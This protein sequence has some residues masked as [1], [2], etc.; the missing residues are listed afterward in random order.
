MSRFESFIKGLTSPVSRD[1]GGT[2][3]AHANRRRAWRERRR[4]FNS[5]DVVEK[6][7]NVN[8][9]A[10]TNADIRAAIDDDN[11]VPKPYDPTFLRDISA[12]AVVQAYIDTLSQDVASTSWDIKPRDETTEVDEAV[13]D[14]VKRS[15]KHL[16]PE[17]S[18]PD[19]LEQTTRILLELGDA[20]WVKHY[21]ERGTIAEAIPVDSSTFFKRVDRYGITEGYVQA[22]SRHDRPVPFETR[23]VIWFEWSN[24]PDR[25]YGQGPLEKA[26]NEVELLEEL[27]YKERLDLEQGS[28]PGVL[29]P[30]AI[31]EFGGL[32]NTDDW[33]AFVD[34]FRLDEGERHR[35]GY[36]PIPVDYTALNPTYQELQ[37][38]ERSKYWVTVL[39]AVFKCNPSYVGFDFENTNR[40]TDE[41][42]Q[43]AYAQRGFRVTLRQIEEAIN[44]NLIWQEFSEDVVFE[45]E[46]EQTVDEKKTKAELV[47][48]QARAGKEM[49]NA[50]REVHYRDGKLVVEDG[51]IEEG[52]AGE[53]PGGGFFGMSE[54][55]PDPSPVE[56][57]AEVSKAEEFYK[58]LSDEEFVQLDAYLYAAHETQVQPKSIKDIEKR[59]WSVDG[60]VPDFVF[61]AIELAIDRGAVFRDF[62]SLPAGVVDRVEG[63]LGDALTQPQGWSLDSIV[64]NMSDAFPGV[65]ETDLETVARTETASVLNTAREDG[66]RSRGEQSDLFRWQ[67][68]ED[69]RTTPA[70]RDLK[71]A[72]G[73][74][75]GTPEAFDADEVPGE[76]VP[77][78][79]LVELE[80]KAH[81]YHFP[82]LRFRR[83]TI[84]PNERHTFVRD[85][86]ASADIE[87]DVDVPSAE[88]FAAIAGD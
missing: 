84:H 41:S 65:D 10:E 3:S 72:T 24:R 46:R 2:E 86:Q 75:S 71:I 42:Q 39:G 45:F 60:D 69:S 74:A 81:N 18:F 57:S 54:S 67:G 85:V 34:D 79:E 4:R 23:E 59:A 38:L 73:T 16:H 36:A 66:Y 21:D 33:E 55:A 7:G 53:E 47:E 88:D 32:P 48:S 40:A 44:R 82:N 56:K 27:A 13:L 20:T 14:T 29:S 58:S 76:A 77:I 64:D 22:T 25:F 15:V 80:R 62:E 70:C 49:A 26:A 30:Q 87:V 8:R 50:G 52:D 63:I 61:E 68:P 78:E 12:N 35:V 6:Q 11:V 31:D 83:H 28:P 1:D 17:E 43:E 51:L 5:P 37:Y 19:V 9:R